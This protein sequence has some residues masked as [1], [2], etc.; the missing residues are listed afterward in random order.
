MKK[1]INLK[2]IEVKSFVTKLDGQEIK[3]G[4]ANLTIKGCD[5]S[6]LGHSVCRT[7]EFHCNYE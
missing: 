7:C 5:V 2:E 4:I 1:K 6:D 3:G